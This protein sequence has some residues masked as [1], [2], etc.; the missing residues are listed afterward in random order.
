MTLIGIGCVFRLS[1]PGSRD[2]ASEKGYYV[3]PGEFWELC[4]LVQQW[5]W[6]SFFTRCVTGSKQS[7]RVLINLCSV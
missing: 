1:N 4:L 6:L 5:S 2:V 7:N 3:G